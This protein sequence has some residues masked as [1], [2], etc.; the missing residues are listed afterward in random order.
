MG[1][2]YPLDEAD[3]LELANLKKFK[4]YLAKHISKSGYT[5]ETA[6]RRK[7]WGLL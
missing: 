5:L 2:I 4:S 6:A 3:N 1:N 7:E